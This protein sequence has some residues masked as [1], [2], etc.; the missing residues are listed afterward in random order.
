MPLK[1][2]LSKKEGLLSYLKFHQMVVENR[3]E[4]IADFIRLRQIE[5]F[6]QFVEAGAS[7]EVLARHPL[8]SEREIQEM[9]NDR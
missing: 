1:K 5:E 2:K 6:I 8:W 9:I 4:K 3:L 7:L